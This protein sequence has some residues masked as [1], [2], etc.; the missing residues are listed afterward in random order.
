MQKIMNFSSAIREITEGKKLTKIEWDNKDIYIFLKDDQLK[1]KLGDG[2][3]VSL[4]VSTGDMVGTDWI[5][6][7]EP[8]REPVIEFA[9]EMSPT[10]LP[11][12]LAVLPPPVPEEE[13]NP[14]LGKGE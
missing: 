6:I 4:I 9:A 1:I 5:V 2:R 10:K 8:K 13:Y 11:T 14:D 7:D 12:S 3:I